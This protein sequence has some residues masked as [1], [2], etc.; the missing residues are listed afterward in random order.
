M[1][2]IIVLKKVDFKFTLKDLDS[3][4][5]VCRQVVSIQCRFFLY[6]DLTTPIKRIKWI[7]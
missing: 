4:M 3:R 6:C 1:T 7:V 5:S 2:K